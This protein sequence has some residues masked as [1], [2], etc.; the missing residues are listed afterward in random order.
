MTKEHV[1]L[2][3]KEFKR[4]TLKILFQTDQLF[5]SDR[6]KQRFELVR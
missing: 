5:L 3:Y 4:N 6:R 1:I 2:N